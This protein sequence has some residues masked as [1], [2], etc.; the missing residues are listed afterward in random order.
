[1]AK[2]LQSEGY[3]W[4]VRM[5][6]VNRACA[7][8]Q[9]LRK[10]VFYSKGFEAQMKNVLGIFSCKKQ[11]TVATKLISSGTSAPYQSCS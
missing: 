5:I 3:E 1:M 6:R 2:Y 8:L 11:F 4:S 7:K 9:R 10:T